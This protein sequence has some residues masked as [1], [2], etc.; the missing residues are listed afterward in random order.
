MQPRFL[1]FLSSMLLLGSSLSSS[2]A[3]DPRSTLHLDLLHEL[4]PDI[5]LLDGAKAASHLVDYRGKNVILHF[6]A[7]WCEPC[8]K[9]LAGLAKLSQAGAANGVVLVPVSGDDSSQTSL[10]KDAQKFISS[11]PGQLPFFI[12]APSKGRDRFLT[13]GVPVTYFID[14]QGK[15]IARALGPRDWAEQPDLGGLL[16][17]IFQNK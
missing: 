2:H 8:K 15:L 6:W 12:A 16:S 5:E 17:Q 14:R 13:W 7:S 11:V 10:V 9:E 4:A 3:G 1:N